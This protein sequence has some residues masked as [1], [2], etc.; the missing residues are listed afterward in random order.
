MLRLHVMYTCLDV[1]A[2]VHLTLAALFNE[3]HPPKRVDFVMAWILKLEDRAGT[4]LCGVERYIDGQ[5]RKVRVW[6]VACG[7]HGCDLRFWEYAM[8]GSMC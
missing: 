3:Y 6:H 5:Y 2:Y 4:P 8:S 1:V 7:V